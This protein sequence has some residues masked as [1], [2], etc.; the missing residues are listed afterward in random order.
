MGQAVS[1]ENSILTRF[2][3]SSG[4]FVKD[5]FPRGRTE[6]VF[7][8]VVF[9][10]YFAL[11]MILFVSS[12]VIE[13]LVP[14]YWGYLGYD[15][16]WYTNFYCSVDTTE[17][18]FLSRHPFMKLF[19]APMSVV[20]QI[21]FSFGGLRAK[22][23]FYIVLFNIVTTFSV[24]GVFRWT[25]NVLG[26]TFFRAI[27]LAGMFTLFFSNLILSFTPESFPIS[28]LILIGS[29]LAAVRF[30]NEGRQV[31]FAD[32]FVWT[33]C[34]GAVTTTNAVCSSIV[35]SL[36]P[37]Q[38]SRTCRFVLAAAVMFVGLYL[39]YFAVF[40]GIFLF[41]PEGTTLSQWFCE[42][43]IEYNRN[44]PN[45][46]DWGGM[47]QW[48]DLALNRFW[49]TSLV[50]S[51]LYGGTDPTLGHL[52][53][54]S[55]CV[56]QVANEL[57]WLRTLLGL[58]LLTLFAL[59]ATAVRKQW[60]LAFPL[61]VFGFNVFLHLILRF[62]WQEPHIYAGHWIF[63]VPMV[64]GGVYALTQNNKRLNRV[65]DSLMIGLTLWLAGCSGES[66]WEFIRIATKQ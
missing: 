18:L 44:V 56:P 38:L 66:L 31:P 4:V 21:F 64:I 48:G 40:G 51:K 45:H 61:A 60:A 50:G 8:A 46:G 15:N 62:G 1:M 3:Y 16:A 11:S 32:Y 37:G 65:I 49:T 54:I 53:G 59:G 14:G 9:T 24:L 41:L 20:G 19:F 7:C 63:T 12:D 26:L 52:E 57:S 17:G 23:L 29:I 39:V 43:Y 58:G 25:R 2:I 35:F 34:G 33:L 36:T 47:C 5:L 30:S 42:N 55:Y 13:Q 10:F 27:L 6:T 22:A 28:Q